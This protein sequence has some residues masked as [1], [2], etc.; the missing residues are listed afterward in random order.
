MTPNE[1]YEGMYVFC[2]LGVILSHRETQGWLCGLENVSRT[3]TDSGVS[4]KWVKFFN[5]E[6][7]IPFTPLQFLHCFSRSA[8][9]LMPLSLDQSSTEKNNSTKLDSECPIHARM[10]TQTRTIRSDENGFGVI[11]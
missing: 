5:F 4:E 7:I 10:T 2:L 1:Q 11:E 9:T 6:R 8:G 3:S